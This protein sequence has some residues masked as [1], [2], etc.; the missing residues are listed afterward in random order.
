MYIVQYITLQQVKACQCQGE[1]REK[2]WRWKYAMG[3][4]L[5]VE[6][7]YANEIYLKK[8]NAVRQRVITIK[9]TCK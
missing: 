2:L 5:G 4:R 3:L 6:R 7:R 1:A 8:S 9:L